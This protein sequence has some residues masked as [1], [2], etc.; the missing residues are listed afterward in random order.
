MNIQKNIEKHI[1]M[2]GVEKIVPAPFNPSVRTS[3]NAILALK[4]SIEDVGIIYPL[5]V[6][7]KGGLIDGH[8]RLACAIA[9]NYKS[10]PVMVIHG[11][12]KRIFDD[13]NRT[14][15]KLG[16]REELYVYLAGGPVSDAA[17]ATIKKLESLVGKKTLEWAA[18]NMVSAK[19]IIHVLSV[20][21]GYLGDQNEEFWRKAATWMI[22]NRQQFAVRVA[23]Q[24]G[25]EKA[26]LVAAIEANT[27]VG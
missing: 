12:A 5:L 17:V 1:T 8:R 22:Y 25:M 14:S 7:E 16:S 4:Q 23:V 2:M 24:S 9:L 13:V 6:T 26:L 21:R 10:V 19:S 18:E 15:R 20:L 27:P 11:D 3:A